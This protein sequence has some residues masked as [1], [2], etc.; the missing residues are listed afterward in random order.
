MVAI[1]DAGNIPEEGVETPGR[2]T[3]YQVQLTQIEIG[4]YLENTTTALFHK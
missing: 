1:T 4:G 2:V 3:H